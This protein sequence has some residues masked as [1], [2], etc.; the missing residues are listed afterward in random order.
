MLTG[1][2]CVGLD[3]WDRG[4]QSGVRAE[5]PGTSE[6]DEESRETLKGTK[7]PQGAYF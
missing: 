4:S 3:L 1:Q 7:L 6:R 2:T 5:K